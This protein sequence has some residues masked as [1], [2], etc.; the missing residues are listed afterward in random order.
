MSHPE[1][2]EFQDVNWIKKLNNDF[3]LIFKNLA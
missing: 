2:P 3:L 1:I